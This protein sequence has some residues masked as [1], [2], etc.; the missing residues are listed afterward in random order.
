M[1][2]GVQARWERRNTRANLVVVPSR[3]S[4]GS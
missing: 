4:P 1:L 3:Y 2:L